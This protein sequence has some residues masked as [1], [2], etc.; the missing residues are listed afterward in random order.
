MYL[1]LTKSSTVKVMPI[2]PQPM[3]MLLSTL[4]TMALAHGHLPQVMVIYTVQATLHKVLV[5]YFQM[6]KMFIS[7][8]TWV[9]WQ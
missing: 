4:A 6:Y 3:A 5:L 1:L 7:V 9:P 8:K 2:L